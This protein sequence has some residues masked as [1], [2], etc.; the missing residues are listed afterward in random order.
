MLTFDRAG[1]LFTLSFKGELYLARRL[2]LTWSQLV[3]AEVSQRQLYFERIAVE[4]QRSLD[5]FERQYQNITLSELL[6]GPMPEDIGLQA[7]LGARVESGFEIFAKA[8]DL[9]ARLARADLVLTGEGS[10]DRQSL[11]GKG[12]G[13]VAARAREHGKPCIGLAGI[14]ASLTTEEASRS[15]F[16]AAHAIVPTLTTTDSAMARAAY[17][18]E[19]L[20]TKVA[21]G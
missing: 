13:R 9:D 4:L 14:V 20:A 15:P 11:M 18:L 10:L 21:R 12:T 6:L 17:W 8:N 3:A 1:G 5:H 16:T 19:T 2:D 7:F